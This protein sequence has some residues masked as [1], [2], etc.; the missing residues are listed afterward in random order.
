[1]TGVR[2]YI[3]RFLWQLV[4]GQRLLDAWPQQ[5][6]SVCSSNSVQTLTS[7]PPLIP[8]LCCS[9]ADTLVPHSCQ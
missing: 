3:T 6:N 2:T 9:A 1:M 5:T 8:T 7:M 4:H